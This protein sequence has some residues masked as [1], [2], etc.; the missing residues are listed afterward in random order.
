MSTPPPATGCQVTSPAS[1]PAARTPSSDL[2][3]NS[4]EARRH[5]LAVCGVQVR[6]PR[7]GDVE[8]LQQRA[9]LAA[10]EQGERR[11]RPAERERD[12]RR[13]VVGRIHGLEQTG[14]RSGGASALPDVL[15]RAALLEEAAERLGRPVAPGERL[16][17]R[18]PRDGARDASVAAE[19]LRLALEFLEGRRG[20]LDAPGHLQHRDEVREA[21]DEAIAEARRQ[22][23]SGLHG[24]L[25]VRLREVVRAGVGTERGRLH[26]QR[27]PAPGPVAVR[28]ALTTH[29]R[30]QRLG[31]CDEVE[32]VLARELLAQLHE[33]GERDSLG[34]R[35][36]DRARHGAGVVC[37]LG[38]P[39][40]LADLAERIGEV[41]VRVGQPVPALKGEP[42]LL[43]VGQALHGLG[44]APL[45]QLMLALLEQL[46]AEHGVRADG[47]PSALLWE[48]PRRL[49][50]DLL[51]VARVCGVVGVVDLGAPEPEDQLVRLLEGGGRLLEP[52]G[53][54]QVP[55]EVSQGDVQVPRP[56]AQG[57]VGLHR[58]PCP[59]RGLGV[60]PL[61]LE[62]RAHVVR[63]RR[64]GA[65]SGRSGG[66]GPLQELLTALDLLGDEHVGVVRERER[67][68]GRLAARL[69][70]LGRAVERERGGT[71]VPSPDLDRRQGLERNGDALVEVELLG[72]LEPPCHER[73]RRVEVPVLPP[74][75]REGP[76]CGVRNDVVSGDVGRVAEHRDEQAVGL[77]VASLVDQ[78]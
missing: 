3:T 31:L 24:A 29:D 47:Q 60:P 37:Q 66:Q 69:L 36:P 71:Q 17:R 67:G 40:S 39:M 72:D 62:L 51:H 2:V 78:L 56:V 26:L 34:E 50:L 6:E 76:Q 42:A 21:V 32:R 43:R 27:P 46:L 4:A 20:A 55:R 54:P 48:Q 68:E 19:P 73:S 30:R 9:G 38:R 14:E 58:A 45:L 23:A 18:R 11:P 63:D 52:V 28:A 41:R 74:A 64:V 1:P 61:A 5:R 16:A 13:L 65:A 10:L 35:V 70:D 12:L 15:V 33:H 75:T 59:V 49:C 57:T 53:V 25:E 7:H 22:L 77:A 44:V 8:C